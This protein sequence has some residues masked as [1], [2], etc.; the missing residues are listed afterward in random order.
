M[1]PSALLDLAAELVLLV[2]E[3]GAQVDFNQR[4]GQFHEM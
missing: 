4:R 1:H 2:G 3:K